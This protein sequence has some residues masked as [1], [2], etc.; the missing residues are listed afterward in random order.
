[1]PPPGIGLSVSDVS[2]TAV[3][4]QNILKQSGIIG[5]SSGM[6]NNVGVTMSQDTF[7]RAAEQNLTYGA[8]AICAHDHNINTSRGCQIANHG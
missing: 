7:G 4:F 3:I 5:I 6:K 2:L 8:M 1:L